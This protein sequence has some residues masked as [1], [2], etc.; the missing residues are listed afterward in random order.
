M[1]THY[2]RQTV[3]R[4]YRTI[5]KLMPFL[6]ISSTRAN[7]DKSMT[8]YFKGQSTELTWLL[9]CSEQGILPSS[10]FKK[11]YGVL[12]G[13]LAYEKITQMMSSGLWQV[14]FKSS[15]SFYKACGDCGRLE[16]TDLGLTALDDRPCRCNFA[17]K[18][19]QSLCAIR[20]HVGVFRKGFS[21]CNYDLDAHVNS[22]LQVENW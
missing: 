2:R 5:M 1:I 3:L 10:Q 18:S 16:D 11:W 9:V 4:E 7:T 21:S 6:R 13:F 14:S 20:M 17:F 8:K 22:N 19:A 12:C 15:N